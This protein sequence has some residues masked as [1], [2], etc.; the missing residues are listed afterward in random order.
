MDQPITQPAPKDDEV[1]LLDHLIVLAKYSR[2][3]VYSSIAVTI[4]T[5]FILF[6]LPNKYA[7][8]AVLLPPQQNVTLSA[9]VLDSLG[10]STSE[11]GGKSSVGLAALMQN[12]TPGDLY[13]AMLKGDTIFDRIIQRFKLR[14]VY[15]VKYI[16]KA[17][18][19][20]NKRV[21]IKATSEGVISIV[22][23]AGDQK[24]AAEMANAFG[25]ELDKLLQEMAHQDARNHL[26]F[27]EKERIQASYNLTKAENAL[28]TFSEKTS[29]VQ[30]EAQAKGMIEYIATLRATI[31]AKEVQ[32]QVLKKAATPFNYDVVRL[33]TEVKGLKGKLRD[34]EA[35]G[36]P[37]CD[38][39][40]CIPTERL[41]AVGLEYLRLYREVKYQ[42]VLYQ[43]YCKL[44]EIA[45]LD[46][47]RNVS[48]VVFVDRAV[49]AERKANNPLLPALLVGIFT[50]FAMIAGAFC[51]EYVQR[52]AESES[53]A[54]RLK[55]LSGYVQQ[56]RQDA[57]GIRRWLKKKKM[58][59]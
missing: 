25:E 29:V 31:D 5:Y 35:Q 54:Q 30:I 45:R 13:A 3:I 26:T 53:K 9:T 11:G 41:P 7:S 4:I 39:D 33:E 57:Q 23:T 2:M 47:A 27:L 48:S 56:W 24:Q 38:G 14:E 18:E 1:R 40:V 34:A 22:V 50:F 17:R 36:N 12:Q 59:E 37:N 19:I 32:I 20:L 6:C 46:T 52:A 43:L 10:I 42:E 8:R 49:P 21:E 44:V 16:E 55:E 28:R 51:R 15:G 58:N